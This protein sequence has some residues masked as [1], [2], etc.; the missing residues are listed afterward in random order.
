[1]V[2]NC[3]PLP[4]IS[5]LIAQVQNAKIFTKVD[6]RWGYNNVCIK[7]G[8]KHKATFI[9]NQGLFEPTIMFFGLMNSPV[10]FQTMMN[11]IFTKEIAEGWLIIYMNDILV[12]TK[13]DIQFYEKG[14]HRMLEKLRKHNL[15]LKLEKCTFEQ[16]RIKFLG[17][18]LQDRTV[19]MDPAKIKGIAD[20]STPQNVTD[21]CSF[22]G[23]MGFYH[24]FI[25]NYSLIAQPLIQL[26]Q[27]N[28]LFNWDQTCMHA[29]KHLKSLMCTKPILQQPNYMKAFFLA[30]DASAYSMGTILLQEGELNPRTQKPMLCPVAY[31]SST[32]TPTERNYNIYEREFLGVPKALKCFR[33]HITAT[34]IPV[35]IL[36]NHTNLTH[37]KATRKV[38]RHVARWFTE[39][40]DYNLVIKHIPGKIHT[41][42]DM[43]SR[44]PGVD[45]GKQDNTNIILLPPSMFVTTANAQD[46]MLK[47]KVRDMQWKQ[48]AEMELWCNTQGVRKLPEGYTK[49]GRLAVLSGLVPR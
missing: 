41:T 14:I 19:Q 37:W 44:P 28:T 47:E 36:T 13:D 31:Y 6:I 11:A 30:T 10:T 35:T 39:I 46:N 2:K 48:R 21:V 12:T 23:F 43:L 49:D 4:L 42:P 5:E 32:F 26:T 33:P 24:Y 1:M 40:Q 25:P 27:K 8:D 38:N 15:Y 20:W 22:L 9:T 34:K 45:Q 29:F 16:Q 18:I 3:Y 7:E 17:V